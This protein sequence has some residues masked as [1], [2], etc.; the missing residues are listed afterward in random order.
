[1][2]VVASF[3]VNCGKKDSAQERDNAWGDILFSEECSMMRQNRPTSF[4]NMAHSDLVID[5]STMLGS[6]LALYNNKTAYKS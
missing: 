5:S 4:D 3:V 6:W 2:M 1:M